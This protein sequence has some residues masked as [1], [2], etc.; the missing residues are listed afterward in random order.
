MSFL[1]ALLVFVGTTILS[2][3]YQRFIAKKP[4]LDPQ[5]W[6]APDVPSGTPIPMLIGTQRVRPICVCYLGDETHDIVGG[7]SFVTGTQVIGQNH[8]VTYQGLL[9]WGM[10]SRYVNLVIND[11]LLV[12]RLAAK[13]EPTS[14]D[15]DG[16]VSYT[17]RQPI[18]ANH[19]TGGIGLLIFAGGKVTFTVYLPD[20]FQKFD[21]IGG[22]FTLYYGTGQTGA[23]PVLETAKGAGNVPDYREL[24][25]VVFNRFR[26]GMDPSRPIDFVLEKGISEPDYGDS[27]TPYRTMDAA[28]LAGVANGWRTWQVRDV[29]IPCAIYGLA[30]SRR[31]SIGIDPDEIDK[32]Q[33]QGVDGQTNG[34]Q[35]ADETTGVS[36]IITSQKQA[37]ALLDEWL[38]VLNA[39]VVRHPETNK[40]QIKR[41]RNETPDQAAID[42]L[43]TFDESHIRSCK[44]TQ[45]S[46]AETYNE[47]VVT[48]SNPELLYQADT[49]VARNDA[50]IALTGGVRSL[51]LSLMSV[52]DPLLAQRIALRELRASSTPLEK[53]TLVL[54]RAAWDL[55][56]GDVFKVN[57]ASVGYDNR[58]LRC[59]S[60]SL[61]RPWS[62]EVT[63]EAIDDVYAHEEPPLTIA[64]RDPLPVSP[65][66]ITEPAISF[67]VDYAASQATITLTVEDPDGRV[68]SIAYAVA[69]GAI[70]P[71]AGDGYQDVALVQPYAITVDRD[72]AAVTYVFLVVSYL[73]RNNNAATWTDTAEIVPTNVPVAQTGTLDGST[74][75]IVWDTQSKAVD[76]KS[77]VIPAS[78]SL[79]I[80]NA[81]PG[82]HGTLTVTSAGGT[83]YTLTLPAGSIYGD[84]SSLDVTLGA[85][86]QLTVYYDGTYYW[87][88]LVTHATTVP[89]IPLAASLSASATLVADFGDLHGSLAA[90]GTMTADLT[91]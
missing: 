43:R 86:D 29:T 41:I 74:N 91:L 40:Y 6:I 36:A 2:W 17:T 49:V 7:G 47:L 34:G 81:M 54:T 35:F 15:V 84:G 63:V 44:V 20:I 26:M 55:T 45:R 23:D 71:G 8:Y 51:T 77:V 83:G 89:E 56:P 73:D 27:F 22:E 5:P 75:P 50:S 42:A 66:G 76:S 18:V 72:A 19:D 10:I 62:N 64:P 59:L 9:C 14:V 3:A 37:K 57:Y 60:T 82:F 33:F 67:T 28:L 90:S 48:F 4:K 80:L 25:Y 12:T 46:W 1:A 79:V 31:W 52:T 87:W 69:V 30:K 58:V 21:G 16:R 70:D 78:R 24:C 39:V 32:T 61:G 85:K 88:N 11:S 38:Q 65:G 53:Q 13:R 68:Q